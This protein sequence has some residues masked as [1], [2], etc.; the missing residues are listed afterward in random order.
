MEDSIAVQQEME[1]IVRQAGNEII[2]ILSPS[3]LEYIYSEVRIQHVA[4]DIKARLIDLSLSMTQDDIEDAA[5]RY[6]ENGDYDCNLDYW[7]NI[8]NLIDDYDKTEISEP[9]EYPFDE[10]GYNPYT[11]GY[12]PDL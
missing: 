5:R 6:V 4:E 9:D 8:D 1:S 2:D 11:G 12:D 7:S 3:Q 10:I